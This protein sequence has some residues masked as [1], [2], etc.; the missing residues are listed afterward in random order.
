MKLLVQTKH[1]QG[2]QKNYQQIL[3]QL[4]SHQRKEYLLSLHDYH[5]VQLKGQGHL[6]KVGDVIIFKMIMS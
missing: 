4:I 6:I 3:N 2:V 5:G 1:L